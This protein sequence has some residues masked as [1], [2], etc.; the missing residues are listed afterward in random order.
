MEL[1]DGKGPDRG[2]W[3]VEEF[4]KANPNEVQEAGV[5]KVHPMLP[6]HSLN[7]ACPLGFL[8][9]GLQAPVPE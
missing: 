4:G 3:V 9:R 1:V 8:P 6:C 7:L 2:L 5:Q